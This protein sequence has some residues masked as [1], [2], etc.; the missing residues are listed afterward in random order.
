[1]MNREEC[2]TIFRI[3]I[4]ISFKLFEFGFGIAE[5]IY[6]QQ[7]KDTTNKCENI[8]EWIMADCVFNIVVPVITMCGVYNL[9]TDDEN[10]E[11][12]Q[13]LLM[14][15]AHIGQLVIAIWSA[16]VYYNINNQ[17]RVFWENNAPK[18]LIFIRIN[19][20]IL[21]IGVALSGLCY[22][23][24]LFACLCSDIKSKKIIKNN[25]DIEAQPHKDLQI[26]TTQHV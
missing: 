18:F 21:W 5:V 4:V 12:K 13:P 14:Q 24:C 1:M 16:I 22:F 19:V 3:I 15:A 23:V 8:F 6:L 9:I 25:N 7:Y 17:C 2:Y 10:N 11:E 20:I 26:C